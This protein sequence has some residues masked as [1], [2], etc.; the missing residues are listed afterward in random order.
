MFFSTFFNIF[1]KKNV[2]LED[3]NQVS[4]EQDND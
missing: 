1:F 2:R 4:R 3:K